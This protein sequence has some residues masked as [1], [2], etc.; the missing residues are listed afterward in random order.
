MAHQTQYNFCRSVRLRYPE[1]FENIK[2]LD[3]GSLDINGSEKHLFQD[4][5][6]IGID[7]H[8]GKNVDIVSAIHEFNYPDEY[9]D[10]IISCECS[11]HDI[12]YP[13]SFKNICRLLKPNG[14]FM[15][16]CATTGR[17]EHGTSKNSP[18]S[19]PFTSTIMSW[20]NYYKN[21]EEDDIRKVMDVEGIFSEYGF[22]V[23][24][25]S[26]DLYFYGIKKQ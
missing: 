25:E 7:I 12:Y 23:N 15:F 13:E 6:D 19:S 16:T 26:H 20:K 18:E 1:Y 17:P 24:D 11:E 2:A 22:S 21:L 9:F 8:E 5:E 14:L 10:T 4:C 3:C